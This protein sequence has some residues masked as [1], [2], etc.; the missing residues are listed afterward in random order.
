MPAFTLPP[1][2]TTAGE[3][4]I[5]TQSKAD[6]GRRSTTG[7]GKTVVNT[8]TM[9]SPG[10]KANC[11]KIIGLLEGRMT[12]AG[13]P[14]INIPFWTNICFVEI[15]SDECL[16]EVESLLSCPSKIAIARSFRGSEAQTFVDFLD[17]VLMHS[18]LDKKLRRRSLR[19]IRKICEA[20]AIVPLLSRQSII[21][22]YYMDTLILT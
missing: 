17:Q 4:S 16:S 12:M 20:R 9:Y 22:Y 15:T 13:Y 8:L 5:P 14:R 19:L 18:H 2:L 7:D 1:I 21:L 6:P 3:P 11:M 10:K